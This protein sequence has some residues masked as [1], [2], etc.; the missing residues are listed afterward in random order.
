MVDHNIS[1]SSTYPYSSGSSE[2]E[3][4]CAVVLTP[5]SSGIDAFN[6][7]LKEKI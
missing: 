7:L 1:L 4:I 3:L 5:I 6:K 2:S